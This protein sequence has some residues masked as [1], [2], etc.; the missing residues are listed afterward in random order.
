MVSRDPQ[1]WHL[2]RHALY[3]CKDRNIAYEDVAKT[4]QEGELTHGDP[5]DD[6]LLFSADVSSRSGNLGVVVDPSNSMVVTVEPHYYD[7][8][9]VTD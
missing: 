9:R 4:I 2:S 8:E 5:S 6:N 1:D 3:R 7:D